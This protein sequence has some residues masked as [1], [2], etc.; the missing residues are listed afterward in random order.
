MVINALRLQPALS[1]NQQVPLC[2]WMPQSALQTFHTL[3]ERLFFVKAL[4][5]AGWLLQGHT[6][7]QCGTDGRLFKFPKITR[8][9][10]SP[11]TPCH[12]ASGFGPLCLSAVQLTAV[13]LCTMKILF[14]MALLLLLLFIAALTFHQ[15]GHLFLF[16]HVQLPRLLRG[17]WVSFVQQV[18]LKIICL[19]WYYIITHLWIFKCVTCSIRAVTFYISLVNT[20][21]YYY[22]SHSQYFSALC[23]AQYKM[24]S[25]H[26]TVPHPFFLSQTTGY[27]VGLWGSLEFITS[28]V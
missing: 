24:F 6:G 25:E 12:W 17:L 9:L 28:L 7:S 16:K 20:I 19:S 8:L 2:K 21:F 26:L 11:E 13:A 4:E 10:A 15:T 22:F 14:D 18:L 1:P 23:S 5:H 3:S 27:W